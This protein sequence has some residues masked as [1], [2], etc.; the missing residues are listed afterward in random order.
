MLII[1]IVFGIGTAEV[2]E[3]IVKVGCAG[4]G[5]GCAAYGV[6]VFEVGGFEEMVFGSG[7]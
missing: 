3:K 4:E 6:V 1:G 5:E 7:G 2:A